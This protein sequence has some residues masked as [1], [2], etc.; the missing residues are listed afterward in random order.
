MLTEPKKKNKKR[1]HSIPE[2]KSDNSDEFITPKRRKTNKFASL[3]DKMETVIDSENDFVTPSTSRRTAVPESDQWSDIQ[4]KKKKKRSK[5]E[6]SNS[7]SSDSGIVNDTINIELTTKHKEKK[8]KHKSSKS[9]DNM[10]DEFKEKV[11]VKRTLNMSLPLFDDD[12]SNKLTNHV[13][14]KHKKKKKHRE[15]I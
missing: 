8:K 2:E 9:N 10:S 12:E 14:H 15:S 3:C 6:H 7:F 4:K 5:R 1:K 11:A 13:K